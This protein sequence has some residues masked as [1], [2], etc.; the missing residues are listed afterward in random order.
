MIKNGKGAVS[1]LLQYEH[2]FVE[3]MIQMSRIHCVLAP[4]GAL[5]LIKDS[6]TDT[7]AQTLI[8]RWKHKHKVVTGIEHKLGLKYWYNFK[9][10][11]ADK[12]ITRRGQK[13]EL[14]RAE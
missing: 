13:F 12:I 11:N 5:A 3:L 9:K 1:R 4:S 10:R 14:D 6:I 8:I 7:A 2:T